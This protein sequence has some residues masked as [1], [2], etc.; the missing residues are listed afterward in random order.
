MDSL[1]KSDPAK[2]NSHKSK[3]SVIAMEE[4]MVDADQL[5]VVTSIVL[6][7]LIRY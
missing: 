7:W 5:A 3:S 1:P 6:G 4:L 2:A